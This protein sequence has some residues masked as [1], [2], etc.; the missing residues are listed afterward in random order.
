[1][2]QERAVQEGGGSTRKAFCTDAAGQ[3]AREGIDVLLL[4]W[5]WNGMSLQSRSLFSV[6]LAFGGLVG[7]VFQ[8]LL[9]GVEL[10]LNKQVGISAKIRFHKESAGFL[11]FL[12][13]G[14]DQVSHI[15]GS[16]VLCGP[17][18]SGHQD[19]FDIASGDVESLGQEFEVDVFTPGNLFRQES[20]PYP[21][22]M[23]VI[24]EGK[25][26]HKLHAPD[27]GLVHILHEIGGQDHDPLVFLYSLQEV[28]D[29]D[30][31]IAIMGVFYLGSLAK[32]G[33]GLIEEQNGI[34]RFRP[35]SAR[36]ASFCQA[37]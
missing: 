11:Q 15:Q 36:K 27:E 18:G 25:L 17:K 1:M 9:H 24:R 14:L 22:P 19:V 7:F 2:S 37:P 23:F 4:L 35:G 21:A 10:A 34:A 29:L 13:T 8:C 20:L 31:G 33:V 6:V 28:A 32:H 26:D 12:L 5:L 16:R 3:N 30:I